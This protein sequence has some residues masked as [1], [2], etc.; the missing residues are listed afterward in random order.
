M[1]FDPLDDTNPSRPFQEPPIQADDTNPSAVV[2]HARLAQEEPTPHLADTNP[3]LNRPPLEDTAPSLV[4][5]RVSTRSSWRQ[6][7]G[8]LSLLG[9]SLFTLATV[10]L[11]WADAST[12]P[13]TPTLVVT[14]EVNILP[15][16]TMLEPTGDGSQVNNADLPTL[17]PDFLARILEQPLVTPTTDSLGITADRFDPFTIIPDRPRNEVIQYTVKSGDTIEGIATQFNLQP[18]SIVWANGAGIVESL[19]I[20]ISLYIPPVDGVLYEHVGSKTLQEI[21]SEYDLPDAYAIINSEYNTPLRS[22]NPNDV[23]PSGALLM[24]AGAQAYEV[25]FYDP[26]IVTEGGDAGA[27]GTYVT[28]APGEAGS[29][30]RV[31]NPGGGA[32]WSPPLN[33]YT[34][35]RGFSGYHTGVDLAA[36]VGTPVYA[37][38]SGRVIFAGW[39]SWGY[40]YMVALAHGP[41]TSIYGHMSAVYVGCGQDVGAGA[42]IG[43]VGSSGNSSGP[44][45]HFEIRYNN[46]P[47]DPTISLA[48]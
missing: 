47:Q 19:P 5:R 22:Y 35:I 40:G 4:M 18:E 43:A 23:P 24:L 28:F 37:A 45:L 46:Q 29:C 21:A 8:M 9:A 36:S 11:V 7:V 16:P 34:W 31:Q 25:S 41:F 15:S 1:S 20:G 38:N 13:P 27:T 6:A 26:V 39:N 48:F 12:V 10:W 2:R 17:A 44:H 3:T 32:F 14:D 33:S 42:N 30:A